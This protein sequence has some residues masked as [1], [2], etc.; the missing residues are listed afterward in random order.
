MLF[1]APALFFTLLLAFSPSLSKLVVPNFPDLT[2]K[3][4]RTVGDR[5]ASVDTLYLK[6]ARQR[7]EFVTQK[8]SVDSVDRVLV[9]ITQCDRKQR[10]SLNPAARTYVRFPIEDWPERMKYARPVPAAEVSGADVTVTIDSFDTGERRQLGRFAARRVKTTTSVEPG[11]GASTPARVEETD[12]WYVDLPGLGCEDSGDRTGVVMSFLTPARRDRMHFKRLGTAR[13]GY[14]IEETTR[15]TEAGRTTLSKVELLEFSEVLLNG[16][17]FELPAS[18]SPALHMP[19]GGYD[20]TR[21]ETLPNQLQ[22]YWAELVRSA[23]RLFR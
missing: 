13:H 23:Q 20:M 12:G 11:P 17:L 19:R 6:G 5:H 9:S 1:I 21:P 4:R 22:E 14:A 7:G 18:Y 2:I 16:A 3:I 15:R 8:P 10:L